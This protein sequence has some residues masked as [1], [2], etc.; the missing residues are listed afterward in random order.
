MGDYCGGG[1]CVVYGRF[2]V[3]SGYGEFF[4]DFGL[5]YG[6]VVGLYLGVFVRDIWFRV[7]FR[8]LWIF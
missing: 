5:L 3:G 4:G 8:I 2:D 7:G 1:I 6:V